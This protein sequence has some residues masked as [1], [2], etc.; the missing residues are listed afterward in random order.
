MLKRILSLLIAV[1]IVMGAV[2]M[3]SADTIS[4][5]EDERDQ[6]ASDAQIQQGIIDDKQEE[7]DKQQEDIDE[8]VLQID[9][10][11][12]QIQ[13]SRDNIADYETRIAEKEGE[14]K[15]MEQE[16]EDNW[17]AQRDDQQRFDCF[18]HAKSSVR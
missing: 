4:E 17:D 11:N 7:I 18:L 6:L 9:E 8:I 5:L 13:T 16:I 12:I 3:T 14:I 2:I 1:F 10:L 15:A